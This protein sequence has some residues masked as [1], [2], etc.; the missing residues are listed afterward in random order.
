MNTNFTF[1]IEKLKS[2][3]DKNNIDES[4]QTTKPH[5]NVNI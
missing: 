4:T 1:N 3:L 2:Y 5:F